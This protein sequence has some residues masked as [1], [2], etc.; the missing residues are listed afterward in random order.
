[1]HT[2]FKYYVQ[3]LEFDVVEE[4]WLN[5]VCAV[6]LILAIYLIWFLV[7]LLQNLLLLSLREGG[8]IP[9]SFIHI[10]NRFH[11]MA[12]QGN[13]QWRGQGGVLNF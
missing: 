2:I 3:L 11:L 10:L 4:K 8:T 9:D 5:Y 13:C 1:M 6:Q 12:Y 7:Q